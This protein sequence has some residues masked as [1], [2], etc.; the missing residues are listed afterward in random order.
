M[1]RPTHPSTTTSTP[2]PRRTCTMRC[3]GRFLVPITPIHWHRRQTWTN[4]HS[5]HMSNCADVE[6]RQQV[7]AMSHHLDTMSTAA[8]Q[9][10]AVA[11][12]ENHTKADS[13]S[14]T[15][16]SRWIG[17]RVLGP[18][19]PDTLNIDDGQQPGYHRTQCRPK[20]SRCRVTRSLCLLFG[21]AAVAETP[22]RL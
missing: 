6:A 10:L 19:H 5:R 4:A 3:D 16:R 21:S 14:T 11:L 1:N 12:Q 7:Q 20:A 13:M 18:E 22:S 2:K 15:M 8:S 9:C 17:D